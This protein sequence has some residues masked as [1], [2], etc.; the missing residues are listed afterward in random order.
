MVGGNGYLVLS[1][2]RRSFVPPYAGLNLLFGCLQRG[3]CQSSGRSS[4]A[5]LGAIERLAS[6]C[7]V[8]IHHRKP[9][10]I[11]CLVGVGDVT[12]DHL[13]E[14]L[15]CSLHDHDGVALGVALG[16][17]IPNAICHL[18]ALAVTKLP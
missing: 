4:K 16:A 12:V 14:T 15:V 1:L 18:L 7:L 8:L 9:I 11:E 5:V 3:Q 2:W 17:D 10:G 6:Q 13:E